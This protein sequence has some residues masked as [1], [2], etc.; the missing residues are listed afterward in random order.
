MKNTS[1][2]KTNCDL[3]TLCDKMIYDDMMY[4]LQH[5]RHNQA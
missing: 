3:R 2:P 1:T 4:D 5:L